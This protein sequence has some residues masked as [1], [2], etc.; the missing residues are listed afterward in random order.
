MVDNTTL[1]QAIDNAWSV[2]LAT[3]RSVE[4]TDSRRCVL[5]RHLSRKWETRES[6]SEDLTCFGVAYLKRLP[7]G[8]C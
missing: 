3:N 8:E 1:R 7:E 2:Y 5:E 6:D 4:V